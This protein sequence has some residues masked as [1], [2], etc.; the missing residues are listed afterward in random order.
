[1]AYFQSP[2]QKSVLQ[3]PDATPMP[4]LILSVFLE[5]Y[6][7]PAERRAL[8]SK[9]L[10]AASKPPDYLPEDTGKRVL[11]TSF[12]DIY[13][14]CVS[15]SIGE[16]LE[17][18]FQDDTPQWKYQN[19]AAAA[20]HW[21]K[22]LS[23]RRKFVQTQQWYLRKNNTSTAKDDAAT[24]SSEELLSETRNENTNMDTHIIQDRCLMNE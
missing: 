10:V 2:C 5:D 16:L 13:R 14:N 21:L 15:A 3:K 23:D 19:R 12:Q 22:P 9:K 6:I 7:S 17:L 18:E 1:M 20:I 8:S 24:N 4:T 11:P